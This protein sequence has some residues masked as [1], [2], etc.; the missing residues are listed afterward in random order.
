MPTLSQRKIFRRVRK[1]RKSTVSVVISVRLSLSISLSI[2]TWIKS[3][4]AERIFLEFH[5]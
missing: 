3:A 1:L 4:P 5:I 2:S